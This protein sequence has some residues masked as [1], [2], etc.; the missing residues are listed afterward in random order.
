MTY[1]WYT[2][3]LI[4]QKQSEGHS[5]AVHELENYEFIVGI[6]TWHGPLPLTRVQNMD[7]KVSA[8]LDGLVKFLE[9]FHE[10]RYINVLIADNGIAESSPVKS[11]KKKE[12]EFDRKG[13]YLIMKVMTWL[14]KTYFQKR[15]IKFTFLPN[16]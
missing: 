4:S 14:T 11:L 16:C 8:S 12:E 3:I 6:T 9:R 15:N 13:S 5:L 1:F 7:V 10:K 2:T